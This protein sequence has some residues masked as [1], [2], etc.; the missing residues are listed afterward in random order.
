MCVC[1][2]VC[3]QDPKISYWMF[4][5]YF[6]FFTSSILCCV[7]MVRVDNREGGRGREGEGGRERGREM[8]VCCNYCFD[9]TDY[10]S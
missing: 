5:R 7:G 1:V 10:V 9:T 4:L 3:V 8:V 6:V 2:C